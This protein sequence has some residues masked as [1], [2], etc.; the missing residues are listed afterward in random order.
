MLLGQFP[1][2]ILER[3]HWGD[4]YVRCTDAGKARF[5]SPVDEGTDTDEINENTGGFGHAEI[6]WPA[7]DDLLEVGLPIHVCH[8]EGDDGP[9]A[10]AR[11]RERGTTSCPREFLPLSRQ[12]W[13]PSSRNSARTMNSSIEDGR[14]CL[15]L[16]WP[17]T[18][19]AIVGRLT[20]PRSACGRSQVR[21]AL[22][23]CTMRTGM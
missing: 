23:N 2:T 17:E 14:R 11:T 4:L 5:L 10:L 15:L 21:M 18:A 13:L 3:D 16:A 6:M 1:P 20:N 12:K 8:Q 22:T 9:D 19:E 7:Y